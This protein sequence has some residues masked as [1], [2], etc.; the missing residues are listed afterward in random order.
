MEW[1]FPA[2]VLF[3]DSTINSILHI[4]IINQDVLLE[5]YYCL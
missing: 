5:R 3:R 2:K 4:I 1:I